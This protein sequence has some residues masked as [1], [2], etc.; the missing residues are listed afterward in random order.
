MLFLMQNP[1]FSCLDLIWQ[2]CW[3][4]LNPLETHI[5]HNTKIYKKMLQKHTKKCP[6][7]IIFLT[8]CGDDSQDHIFML[9][10]AIS[11]LI[12]EALASQRHQKWSQKIKQ[13]NNP[14][15]IH[16]WRYLGLGCP[17]MSTPAKWGLCGRRPRARIVSL[18]LSIASQDS[19]ET[20][21][22]GRMAGN[23][24]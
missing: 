12:L 21:L 23:E 13:K 6:K 11:A 3:N 9:S 2:L 15:M 5:Q 7:S 16:F 19:L 24:T 17:S 22:Q 10:G 14:K 8:R 20:Y 1:V 4:A 18:D